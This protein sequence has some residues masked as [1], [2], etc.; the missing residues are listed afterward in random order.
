[1][2]ET[3]MLS[4]PPEETPGP[5]E[6]PYSDYTGI[7]HT[8]S[9]PDHVE[10]LH[11]VTDA[12]RASGEMTTNDVSDLV[13]PAQN[14]SFESYFWRVFIV[15]LEAHPNVEIRDGWRFDP[16]NALENDEWE[17]I[18]SD[19]NIHARKPAGPNT[20]LPPKYHYP[21]IIRDFYR[22][23]RSTYE[24]DD[25]RHVVADVELIRDTIQLEDRHFKRCFEFL[26]EFPDIKPPS[27]LTEEPDFAWVESTDTATEAKGG[28][29][30]G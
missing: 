17:A 11:R 2:N 15:D 21:R 1:M 8:S 22:G 19:F 27:S 12:L 29:A 25:H 13:T 26:K 10:N 14:G 30:H 24:A 3:V 4:D 16:Q 28:E 5:D 7:S 9:W 23:I 20:P 18:A 6:L